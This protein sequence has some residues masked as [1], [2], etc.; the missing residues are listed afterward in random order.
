MKKNLPDEFWRLG[1]LGIFSKKDISAITSIIIHIIKSK[2]CPHQSTPAHTYPTCL[3]SSHL[4]HTRPTNPR[5][6]KKNKRN[7]KFFIVASPP[8]PSHLSSGEC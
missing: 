7:S 6:N 3:I 1:P 5:L 2:T 8:P 4:F